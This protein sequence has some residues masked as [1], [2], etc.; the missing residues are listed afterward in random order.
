MNK[1]WN[2][3]IC[4]INDNLFN[5]F[6]FL[7]TIATLT[8]IFFLYTFVFFEPVFGISKLI[9]EKKIEA[10]LKNVFKKE[11][12]TFIPLKYG[13]IVDGGFVN[14]NKLVV[15]IQDLHCH[16]EVQKN[17][18]EIVKLLDRKFG[19]AKIFVEGAPR[20]KVQPTLF[21]TIP[22]NIR[23]RVLENLLNKGMIGAAEYYVIQE[24]KSELYGLEDWEIYI[25]NLY[26]LRQLIKRK[27]MYKQI[28]LKLKNRFKKLRKYLSKDIKQVE[29]TF[30]KIKI[31]EKTVKDFRFLNYLVK[32]LYNYG[33]GLNNYPN[34]RYY[35]EILLLSK[36]IDF[37]KLNVE[38]KQYLRDLETK[39]SFSEYDSLMKKLSQDSDEFYQEL[40]LIYDSTV[41][42]KEKFPNL[43]RFIKYINRAR[44]L[45]PYIL[46]WELRQLEED[47][48]S[49]LSKKTVDKEILFISKMVNYLQE[50]VNLN[51]TEEEFKFLNKHIPVFKSY[52]SKY[53]YNDPKLLKD[54][55]NILEDRVLSDFYLTNI[56]RNEIMVNS[57][58]SQL[59]DN[60]AVFLE[61]VKLS[62]GT[63]HDVVNR[64]NEFK[65]ISVV[66]VGGFHSKIS[67]YLLKRGISTLVIMPNASKKYDEKIY[68]LMFT[69]QIGFDAFIRAAFAPYLLSICDDGQ[70]L[71]FYAMLEAV[72]QQLSSGGDISS[73]IGELNQWLKVNNISSIE[74]IEIDKSQFQIN[75]NDQK[76]L[77]YSKNGKIR[78]KIIKERPQKRQSVSVHRYSVISQ[79]IKSFYKFLISDPKFLDILYQESINPNNDEETREVYKSVYN[80][81]KELEEYSKRIKTKRGVF[82]KFFQIE[83]VRFILENKRVLLADEMGLGKTVQTIV[84]AENALRSDGKPLQRILVIAPNVAVENWRREI[85]RFSYTGEEQILTIKKIRSIISSVKR[86]NAGRSEEEIIEE[87]RK[88]I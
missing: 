19:I 62:K 5:N 10:K 23:G 29:N 4:R 20:E 2:I 22:S 53:F 9:E 81:Y 88:E 11:R 75:V 42:D 12:K 65:E 41:S 27:H 50:Y 35:I 63:Y 74:I 14:E 60:K 17:I 34:L 3:R 43:D 82:L 71:T 67:E 72:I 31:A 7:K 69:K 68:D 57:V 44:W 61:N 21:S 59:L 78:T 25:Q 1:R 83:G 54:I 87:I 47:V 80:Y 64:I 39:L 79:L 51:I 15:I 16:R 38:I 66:I 76:I 6:M 73:A 49:K 55:Q 30:N 28:T 48:I 70:V 77:I 52:L 13:Y 58:I 85:L 33:I 84:A 86:R 26:R 46:T 32:I 56:K 37:K 18:Y 45:N 24:N 8:L 36:Q 40:S